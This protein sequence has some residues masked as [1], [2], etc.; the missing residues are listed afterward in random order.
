M[1]LALPADREAA[2]LFAESTESLRRALVEVGATDKKEMFKV[3]AEASGLRS[4]YCLARIALEEGKVLDKEGRKS[5]GAEKFGSAAE[6]LEEL[7]KKLESPEDQKD[8][9]LIATL[10]KA[11]RAMALGEAEA[12]PIQFANASAL[13]EE[14]KELSPNEK[15]K[16][17][18]LGHSRF[19]KALE[20][21]AQFMD[22]REAARHGE[23]V[24]H[25]E[26]AAAYYDRAGFR[27]ASEYA[28]ASRLMFDAYASMDKAVREADYEKRAKLYG[29]IE[30]ILE[31]AIAGYEKAGQP[32]KREEVFRL[33]ERAKEERA[34]AA[35]LTAVMGAPTVVAT[36]AAFSTP[37]ATREEPVGLER[38]EHADIQANV[39]VRR[40]DIQVGED[41]DVEI[42]L[43]NAGR[44]PAQL[45]KVTDFLPEGFELAEAPEKCRL[46]DSYLNL[47]GRRLDPLK[48]EEVKL[49][50]RPSVQGQFSLSPRLLYLDDDGRYKSFEPPAI[51]ITV[52]ELGLSGWLKGPK[53]KR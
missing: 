15:A 23:A 25:L 37:A 6:I 47:K 31:V 33:L 53:K 18:V 38:F 5:E 39:L 44:G 46:E 16:M 52:K 2:R 35:S 10:A 42:E 1:A 22:R 17:L 30:K 26:S 11:W 41:L 20:A 9:R 34:L 51:G 14:T 12:S 21:G 40:K 3:L 43:V 7:L 24:Q 48:T 8:V 36:T 28:K 27:P 50:L 32:G 29:T 19:C 45:V 49:V 13:F 4:T